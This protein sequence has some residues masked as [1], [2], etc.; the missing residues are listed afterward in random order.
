VALVPDEGAVEEFAA[1]P[2]RAENLIHG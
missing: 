1:A 2:E